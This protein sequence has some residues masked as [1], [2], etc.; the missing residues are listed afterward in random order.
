MTLEGGL[1]PLTLWLTATRSKQLS[2][3]SALYLEFQIAPYHADTAYTPS[4]LKILMLFS[5]ILPSLF[6]HPHEQK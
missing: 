6:L 2:Y 3:S 5:V 1:E 4:T